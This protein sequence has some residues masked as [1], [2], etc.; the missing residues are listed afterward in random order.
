[1][2]FV[3]NI[4]YLMSIILQ[5]KRRSKSKN[6]NIITLETLNTSKRNNVSEQQ[7]DNHSSNSWDLGFQFD[8]DLGVVPCGK[9]N[10]FNEDPLG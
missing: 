4:S 7:I 1:M 6:N 3:F 8:E 5:V 9:M 10:K 2:K